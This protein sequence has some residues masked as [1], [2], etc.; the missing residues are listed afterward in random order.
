MI[1]NSVIIASNAGFLVD[2]LREKMHDVDFRVI[3]ANNDEDLSAR[4]KI[5]YFRFVFIEQCFSAKGTDDYLHRIMKSHRNSRIVIWTASDI[6]PNEA[7]RY[8]HAGAESFFSL[9]DTTENLKK[10]LMKITSG[11]RYCPENIEAALEN[12]NST[13]IFDVPLTKRE[14]QII[15]LFGYEDK[16][17]AKKLSLSIHTVV[18][19]K[20]NIYRK[21]PGKRKNK[22][23]SEAIKKGIIPPEEVL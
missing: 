23:L 1:N 5:S 14:I 15:R 16:E 21:F 17:I 9:R 18:F 7:A 12:D 2:M 10:I 20:T 11:L 3:V 8:I 13:P 22:I 4:L 6:P 19:H